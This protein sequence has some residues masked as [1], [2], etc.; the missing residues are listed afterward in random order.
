MKRPLAA[1]GVPRKKT[2]AEVRPGE[3]CMSTGSADKIRF[4]AKLEALCVPTLRTVF[5]SLKCN[6]CLDIF[7][8]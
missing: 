2:S 3:D 8:Q 4:Q 7:E 5:D 6:I 1:A